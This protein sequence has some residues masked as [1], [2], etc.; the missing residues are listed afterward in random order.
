M[1]Y[2][3]VTWLL[4]LFVCIWIIETSTT[5]YNKINFLCIYS[6]CI[7]QTYINWSV[8]IGN[9]GFEIWFIFGQRLQ[10][11]V[12]T[13]HSD[14]VMDINVSMIISAVMDGDNAMMEVTNGIV[15]CMAML[16][17]WHRCAVNYRLLISINNFFN[18]AIACIF[19]NI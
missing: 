17:C 11:S 8:K 4:H 14:V 1:S 6:F 2:L 18:D 5:M 15:V 12:R 16:R 19:R 9:Y 3:Q 10:V 7:K 13:G